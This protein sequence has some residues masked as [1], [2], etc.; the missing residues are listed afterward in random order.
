MRFTLVLRLAAISA[1]GIAASPLHADITVGSA[2]SPPTEDALACLETTTSGWIELQVGMT[3]CFRATEHS[4]ARLVWRADGSG[5]VESDPPIQVEL[6]RESLAPV[7]RH[8]RLVPARVVRDL[9]RRIVRAARTPET[10]TV[11]AGAMP[12]ADLTWSCA[13]SSRH[14]LSFQMSERADALLDLETRAIANL[15]FPHPSARR[16]SASAARSRRH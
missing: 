14:H 16:Q 6:L 9:A 12:Y 13:D 15:V 11:L 8:R 4:G 10:D 7:P 2:P 3:F 5:T 1:V